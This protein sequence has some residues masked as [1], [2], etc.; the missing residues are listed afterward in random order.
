MDRNELGFVSKGFIVVIII[1]VGLIFSLILYMYFNSNNYSPDD[2]KN[3]ITKADS[4]EYSRNLDRERKADIV[5]LLPKARKGDLSAQRRLVSLYLL[6]KEKP[7]AFEWAKKAAESGDA[8][9]YSQLAYFYE[10]GV[11][12]KMDIDQAIKLYTLSAEEGDVQSQYELSMLEKNK[13]KAEYWAKRVHE[14]MKDCP[15]CDLPT[16]GCR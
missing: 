1:V 6:V 4:D 3:M 13:E 16:G 9:A 15:G 8:T 14:S 5:D 12:A 2:I 11:G 10:C 7:K